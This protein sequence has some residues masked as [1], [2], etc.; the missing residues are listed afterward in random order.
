MT[1]TNIPNWVI[2]VADEN[3]ELVTKLVALR[4]F[5][6]SPEFKRLDDEAR[7]LLIDQLITME[8]YSRLLVQRI[9]HSAKTAK[10]VNSYQLTDNE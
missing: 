5:R 9:K 2:K 7:S 4:A 6:E 10:T 8:E 1:D 3:N